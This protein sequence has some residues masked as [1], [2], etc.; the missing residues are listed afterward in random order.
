MRN[1]NKEIAELLLRCQNA[2]DG[3][4]CIRMLCSSKKSVTDNSHGYRAKDTFIML[5]L[6]MIA[7]K[8]SE[9][10][11]R[12]AVTPGDCTPY[13]VYIQTRIDGK[14]YQVS[15]HSLDRRLE[16]FMRKSFRIKWDHGNSRDSAI[17]IYKHYVP[18]GTYT[19]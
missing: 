14:K 11:F 12:F 17:T 15:F 10:D 19:N 7:D 9:S 16:R 5:M 13:L 2:S 8:N 6:G 4:K 1:V 18:N 3:G